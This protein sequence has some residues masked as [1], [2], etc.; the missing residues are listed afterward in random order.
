MQKWFVIGILILL[1]ISCQKKVSPLPR[2]NNSSIVELNKKIN[3]SIN[4]YCDQSNYAQAFAYIEKVKSKFSGDYEVECNLLIARA[5]IYKRVENY[6]SVMINL[7]KALG[8]AKTHKLSKNLINKILSELC[9]AYFDTQNFKQSK[10]IYDQLRSDSFRGLDKE[11][12]AYLKMQNGYL[13]YKS[14]DYVKSETELIDALETMKKYHPASCPPILGKFIQLYCKTGQFAKADSCYL[15]S[16]EYAKRYGIKKYEKYS[17]EC[18]YL[19]YR[20]RNELGKAYEYLKKLDSLN[21]LLGRFEYYDKV[22][23]LDVRYQ[24]KEKEKQIVQAKENENRLWIYLVFSVVIAILLI[25]LIFVNR[26]RKKIEFENNL[27]KTYALKLIERTENYNKK[28]AADLHDGISH[29]LLRLKISNQNQPQEIDRI[30]NEVRRISHNLHPSMFEQIGLKLSLE[31]LLDNLEE[32]TALVVTYEIDYTDELKNTSK[33]IIIYRLVQEIINN[34]IKHA[35]ASA[36]RLEL[37]CTE[38]NWLQLII[39]DNGVGFNVSEA[40]RSQSFFG[41]KNMFERVKNLNGEMQIM[42]NESGV[43]IFIQI[44]LK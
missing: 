27:K 15:L 17:A 42:S 31:Q 3:D 44:P 23:E 20:D 39:Q 32:S 11:R 30:I 22:K 34:T 16:L 41:L 38:Y 1:Q 12:L 28:I 36:I 13:F 4:A 43:K 33:E 24:T 40:L 2:L 18:A 19:G 9:F 5:Q 21:D 37:I 6:S 25:T 14:G 35:N 7:K 10:L 8:I 26:Q 29:E